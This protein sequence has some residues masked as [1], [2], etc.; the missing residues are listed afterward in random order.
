MFLKCNILRVKEFAG[1]IFC[2][3][4]VMAAGRGE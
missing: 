2:D 4:A 1:T 3:A